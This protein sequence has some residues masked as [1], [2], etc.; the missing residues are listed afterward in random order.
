MRS[1]LRAQGISK[2]VCNTVVVASG[3]SGVICWLFNCHSGWSRASFSIVALGTGLGTF[4]FDLTLDGARQPFAS[5]RMRN[6]V[7]PWC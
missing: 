4:D 6:T 1:S 5:H 7:K 3:W 2:L